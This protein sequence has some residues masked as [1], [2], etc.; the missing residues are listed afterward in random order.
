MQYGRAGAI[1]PYILIYSKSTHSLISINANSLQN[2]KIDTSLFQY[3][4]PLP[5]TIPSMNF[6]INWERF[7]QAASVWFY[8]L[9]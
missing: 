4:S 6:I 7:F 2:E 8:A 3:P 9:L 1:D 5:Y